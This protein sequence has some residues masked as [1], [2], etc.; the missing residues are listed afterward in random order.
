V[1][2]ECF[3]T[4]FTENNGKPITMAEFEGCFAEKV[5]ASTV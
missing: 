4:L 1:F 5:S 3:A 2:R